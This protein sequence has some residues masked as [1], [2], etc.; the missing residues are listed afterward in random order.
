MTIY[1]RILATTYLLAFV[2]LALTLT[3]W[4]SIPEVSAKPF[5]PAHTGAALHIKATK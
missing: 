4:E 2:V 3:V 1:Q 5:Y